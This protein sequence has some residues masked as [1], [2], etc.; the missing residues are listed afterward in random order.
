[1]SDEKEERVDEETNETLISAY[2]AGM[3]TGYTRGIIVMAGLVFAIDAATSAVAGDAWLLPTAA[4]VF[5]ALA[6]AYHRHE[7]KGWE[8]EAFGREVGR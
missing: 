7:A 6:Y 8:V 1:M 4:V 3:A 5:N 2:R